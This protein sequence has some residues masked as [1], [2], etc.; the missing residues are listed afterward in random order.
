MYYR[1]QL[2]EQM[3]TLRQLSSSVSKYLFKF[4]KL[5]TRC[6]IDEQPWMLVTWFITIL[7]L[8]INIKVSLYSLDF[9]EEAYLKI[10]EIDKFTRCAL[11]G[12][13]L[14]KPGSRLSLESL[15][16]LS[17]VLLLLGEVI[18]LLQRP[19]DIRMEMPVSP[20][21]AIIFL[22]LSAITVMVGLIS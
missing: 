18:V 2:M 3:L 16:V 10:L 21:L 22:T 1:T 8:E 11:K 9:F 6:D 20:N 5:R 15:G 4:K 19:Q 14:S 13:Q 12:A 7:R 17:L